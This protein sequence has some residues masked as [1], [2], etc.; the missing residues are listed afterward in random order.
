[1]GDDEVMK[2]GALMNGMSALVREILGSCL[3]PPAMGD[4]A[5]R[6]PSLIQHWALTRLYVNS[7]ASRTVREK[8]LSFI[9]H[10]YMVFCYSSSS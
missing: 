8:F 6:P 4:M 5:R 10:P 7:P 3:V 2:V 9:R 1:M